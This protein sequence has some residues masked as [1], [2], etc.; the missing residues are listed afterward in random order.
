M[1]RI[2]TTVEETLQNEGIVIAH[3]ARSTGTVVGLYD[4]TKTSQFDPDG[5]R[6][7]TLCEDHSSIVNHETRKTAER[8]MSAPEEW[9]EECSEIVDT[10]S[11]PIEPEVRID[12]MGDGLSF[13]HQGTAAIVINARQARRLADRLMEVV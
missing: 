3:R 11:H 12:P 5:G 2:E 6:W 8:F 1:E 9:C 10:K 13:I 7:A 4:T